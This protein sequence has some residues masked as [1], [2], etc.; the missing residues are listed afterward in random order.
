ML[1]GIWSP[2]D[3]SI[4][5]DYFFFHSLKSQFFAK[6]VLV[7]YDWSLSDMLR[8]HTFIESKKKDLEKQKS[9]S[10]ECDKIQRQDSPRDNTFLLFL[11]K[12]L[13]AL[14]SMTEEDIQ[15]IGEKLFNLQNM[16]SVVSGKKT[17][18]GE[19]VCFSER[20]FALVGCAVSLVVRNLFFRSLR[21]ALNP[22]IFH[23]SY[24]NEQDPS[25]DFF[26]GV[27]VAY[28]QEDVWRTF[29]EEYIDLWKMS[30]AI[31]DLETY[32]SRP[33]I[34]AIKRISDG[35]AVYGNW[36]TMRNNTARM[37]WNQ[38]FV[39][40]EE[41]EARERVLSE[42]GRVFSTGNMLAQYYDFRNLQIAH[43]HALAVVEVLLHDLSQLRNRATDHSNALQQSRV[44]LS[45][46]WSSLNSNE[47]PIDLTESI[48]NAD[49]NG[50]NAVRLV[51]MINTTLSR[52][53]VQEIVNDMQRTQN[54]SR[55]AMVRHFL[56]N[57]SRN[58]SPALATSESNL[59]LGSAN[60]VFVRAVA[61][62]ASLVQ[63]IRQNH[64]LFEDSV[65]RPD[66]PPGPPLKI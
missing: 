32:M 57:A 15:S 59:N 46:V 36:K 49:S 39:R 2:L 8:S 13:K 30:I 21:W 44:G 1:T 53:P 28:L 29:L 5:Q 47:S 56:N 51:N 45:S 60:R 10:C 43:N 63:S 62:P 9:M 23:A 4:S 26:E 6:F 37:M 27:C 18:A 48:S 17:M 14:T 42:T 12:R 3:Y 38:N 50:V 16:Q 11:K 64:N 66:T 19:V 65:G 20:Y 7:L 58:L 41:Q 34:T 61:I 31:I 33:F 22:R 24:V 35:R 40:F 55:A 25:N 54:S 52:A